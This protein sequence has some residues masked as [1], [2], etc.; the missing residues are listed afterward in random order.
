MRIG[1]KI[2]SSL[3]VHKKSQGGYIVDENFISLAMAQIGTM[4]SQGNEVFLVSSGAV[5]C[6]TS[7]SSRSK[8]LRAAVGQHKLMARYQSHLSDHGIDVAQILLVADELPA[9]QEHISCL[10]DEAFA[11]G[12]LPVFNANDAVNGEEL[13]RLKEFTDNDQLFLAVCKMLRP[14]KAIIVTDV[15]GVLDAVGRVKHSFSYDADL[16]MASKVSGIIE[17]DGSGTGGMASKVGVALALTD[18]KIQTIIVNGREEDFLYRAIGQLNNREQSGD[19]F[20][21]IF[22]S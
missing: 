2:G 4:L 6:D 14:E 21:T 12:C 3:L 19:N 5:V 10:V 11:Y 9:N 16:S 22:Y 7:Y 17:N 18:E 20:G 15:D 8:E 13:D 1:V